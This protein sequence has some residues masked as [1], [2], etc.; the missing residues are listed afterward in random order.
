MHSPIQKKESRKTREKR[1][2]LPGYVQLLSVY[3][4]LVFQSTHSFSRTFRFI[5]TISLP[6]ATKNLLLRVKQAVYYHEYCK[7]VEVSSWR[8]T[9]GSFRPL[10]SCE[11][12]F[13]FWVPSGFLF[14][15]RLWNCASFQ[16]LSLASVRKQGLTSRTRS[17]NRQSCAPLC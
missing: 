10:S 9:S 6:A 4:Q 15:E 13:D 1:N 17:F 14:G 5:P 11:L 12:V 8:V 2:I 3:R 7:V 16:M